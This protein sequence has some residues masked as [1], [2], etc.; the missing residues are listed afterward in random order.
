M[1][2][3]ILAIPFN[4]K[5][6][7]SMKTRVRKPTSGNIKTATDKAIVNSPTTTSKSRSRL[8]KTLANPP[9]TT[10]AIQ[11]TVGRP[12]ADRSTSRWQGEDTTRPRLPAQMLTRLLLS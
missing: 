9:I 12:K 11:A 7:K 2:E 10:L 1:P 4:K 3:A 8:G 5:T 6:N